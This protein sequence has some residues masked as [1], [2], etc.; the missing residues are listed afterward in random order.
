MD[1]IL[2]SGAVRVGRGEFEP[3]FFE[4]LKGIRDN[5]A[6]DNEPNSCNDAFIGSPDTQR[7]AQQ[8][9]QRDALF[10]RAPKGAKEDYYS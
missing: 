2:G 3:G 4:L 9:F 7:M 8:I 1:L 5:V 6:G 10:R